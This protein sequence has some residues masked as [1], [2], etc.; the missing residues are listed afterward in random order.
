MKARMDAYRIGLTAEQFANAPNLP[1]RTISEKSVKVARGCLWSTAV[2]G[3][4]LFVLML[5]GSSVLDGDPELPTRALQESRPFDTMPEINYVVTAERLAKS[6]DENA[7]AA[8]ETFLN[9]WI[10]VSGVAIR[11]ED[12][13]PTIQLRG[14]EYA[15]ISLLRVTCEFE[16]ASRP[17]VSKV[18]PGDSVIIFGKVSGSTGTGSPALIMC[19]LK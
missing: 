10:E 8:N 12:A 3:L 11:I 19:R 5:I 15:G 7:V 2:I 9:K 16:H 13:P 4:L 6:Y 18:K 17:Q 1:F 14:S